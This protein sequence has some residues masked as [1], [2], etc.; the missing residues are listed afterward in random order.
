[1]PSQL[2]LFYLPFLRCVT[3]RAPSPSPILYLIFRV[4]CYQVIP[5]LLGLLFHPPPPLLL[6]SPPL[7]SLDNLVAALPLARFL[8]DWQPIFSR[9][10]FA[11][12]FPAL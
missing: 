10:V 4:T 11:I 1:M 8:I 3:A 12:L 7:L 9:V 6:G 2:T 5:P